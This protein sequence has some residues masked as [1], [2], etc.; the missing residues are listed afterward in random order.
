MAKEQLG[1]N[2]TFTGASKGLNYYTTRKGT[3]VGAVSG[4]IVMTTS[5][6]TALEFTTG[7][8]VIIA[9][10]EYGADWD[11]AG[12]SFIDLKVEMNGETVYFDSVRRDVVKF[13]TN[14]P[15]F[16]IAPLTTFKVLML[17]SD[18]NNTPVTV[19]LS[20]RAYA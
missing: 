17:N 1:S 19:I 10:I 9:N 13:R 14:E 16:V 3:F 5:F 11:T 12:A 2:A 4:S 20:G 8:E 15:S 6:Q 7:S 18:N